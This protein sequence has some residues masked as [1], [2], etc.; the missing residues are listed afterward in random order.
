D[1]GIWLRHIPN[2]M[3]TGLRTLAAG[4]LASL[5]AVVLVVLL[6]EGRE[7][8]RRPLAPLMY[9]ALFLP[10]LVPQTS[11]LPGLTIRYLMLFGTGGTFG[12][13][14]LSHLVFVLPYVYLVL[15]APW[16]AFDQ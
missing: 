5:I 3:D 4:L 10:L 12:L 6:L 7:R 8:S 15:A 2:L 13:V 9:L 11:F 16:R 14:V 1:T